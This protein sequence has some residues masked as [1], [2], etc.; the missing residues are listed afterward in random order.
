VVAAQLERRLR[1]RRVCTLARTAAA[2]RAAAHTRAVHHNIVRVAAAALTAR[3]ARAAW[4]AWSA[5][6]R[7]TRQCRALG[8]VV[9]AERRT[10]AAAAAI[11]LWRTRAVAHAASTRRARRAA[12][13]YA[14]LIGRSGRQC[15]LECIAVAYLRRTAVAASGGA[16]QVRARGLAPSAQP[17]DPKRNREEAALVPHCAKHTVSVACRSLGSG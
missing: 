14:E 5:H 15:A 9:E 10:R 12:R 16:A 2:W 4:A 3:T 7:L 8:A 11:G 1:Q 13:W 17:M 6:V